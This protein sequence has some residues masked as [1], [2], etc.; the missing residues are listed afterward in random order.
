MTE[1]FHDRLVLI[2]RLA[3][4][5][6][7]LNAQL[8]TLTRRLGDEHT[9]YNAVLALHHD[10][11]ARY[12]T[13]LLR[14]DEESSHHAERLARYDGII[15]RLDGER[16]HHAERLTQYETIL[17]RLAEES[18]HHAEHL[19]RLDTILQAIKDLLTRPNGR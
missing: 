3:E 8:L 4:Q 10:R 12:D 1:M 11:L 5:Q 9:L 2:E 6:L 7:D 19:E 13:I 15:A 16:A 17:A 14:L 18:T